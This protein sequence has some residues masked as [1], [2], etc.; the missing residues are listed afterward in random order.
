[1]DKQTN[2]KK[3]YQPPRLKRYGDVRRL[4]GVKGG[5]KIDGA[6]KPRTRLS[7]TSA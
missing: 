6:A 3:P 1:M 5:S 4:T 2:P 7:G